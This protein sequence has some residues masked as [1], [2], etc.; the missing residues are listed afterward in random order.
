MRANRLSDMRSTCVQGS[1][2]LF[3]AA[4][5]AGVGRI[6]FV[7]TISAFPGC[8][9]AY[10][11][12]KL[13]VEALLRGGRNV[14]LRAGL[15][16]GRGTGGVFGGIRKQVHRGGILPMIGRGDAPQYLLHEETL[17]HTVLRAARGDFDAARGAPITLAHPR[18]WPFRDLVQSI[19]RAQGRRVTLVPLPWQLLYAG[20]RAGEALGL[21][22]P[23]R[24]DSVVSFVNCDRHPDFGPMRALG[25]DPL[26]YEG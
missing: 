1:R 13:E 26:P 22:L 8:R 21:S 16:F 25:I 15:V 18:P 12:S 7:S 9:S 5:R 17:V 14:V 20:I 2:A 11:S 23:F 3:E 19:A 10:G 24:S 6:V 4:A